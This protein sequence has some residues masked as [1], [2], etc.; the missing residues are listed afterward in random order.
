L[1]TNEKP[2]IL[3]SLL[4]TF[5]DKKLKYKLYYTDGEAFD[6]ALLWYDQMQIQDEMVQKQLLVNA[7]ATGKSAEK[8]LS[9]LY[10]QRN[11]MDDGQFVN[12]IIRLTFQA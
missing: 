6:K 2:D 11:A 7:T 12:E 4:T 8:L 5:T 1:T 3:Q 10:T 9:D